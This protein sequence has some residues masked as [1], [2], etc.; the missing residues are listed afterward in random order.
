M[1]KIKLYILAFI[2]FGCLITVLGGI[3]IATQ[4][5]VLLLLILAAVATVGL[6]LWASER[7]MRASLTA[8]QLSEFEAIMQTHP[9]YKFMSRLSKFFRRS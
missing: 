4:N 3:A 1:L 2:V 5:T 6:V 7:K 9:L 8:E